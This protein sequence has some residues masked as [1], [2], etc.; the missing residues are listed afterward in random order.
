MS[1]FD[2]IILD[3]FTMLDEGKQAEEYKARKKREK[4]DNDSRDFQ[5]A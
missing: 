1:I 3:E 4:R 2:N 5:K